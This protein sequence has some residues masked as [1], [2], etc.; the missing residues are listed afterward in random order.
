M[1]AIITL[2][3]ILTFTILITKI[4][5]VALIH[6]GLSREAA[7]FQARSALSGV[8]FTTSESE[9][10]VNHPVRRKIILL[11]M[12]VGNIGIVTVVSSL[13]I[14]FVNLGEAQSFTNR[15]IILILGIIVL[16]WIVFSKWVDR[17]LSNVINWALKRYTDI[18]IQDYSTLLHL[19][20]EYSV[21]ELLVEQDDWLANRTLLELDLIA[22]G[23]LILGITRNDG[24]YI[25]T[26]LAT[27]TIEPFDNLILYGRVSCLKRLDQ[28]Q[29]GN[30]GDRE[31][32]KAVEEQ[33]EIVEEEMKEDSAGA[34]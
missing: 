21:T 11:L 7:K 30:L 4:T 28:R 23:I 13:I 31:H 9:K 18:D 8:G 32:E 16:I 15:I 12:M 27:T 10:I 14:S 20:G 33:M 3:V 26:P 19:A 1:I 2:L 22:E 24:T 6:T 34:K 17:Q 5:T 29:K 25:G